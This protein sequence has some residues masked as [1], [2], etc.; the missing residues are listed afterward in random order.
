MAVTLKLSSSLRGFVEG[1]DSLNGLEV[2]FEPQQSVSDLMR[3]LGIPEDKVKVIM[4]NG[5]HASPDRIMADGDR[6]AI[7]PAVGGG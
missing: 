6:L 1:Y 5:R 3:R 4:V 2:D 7:F